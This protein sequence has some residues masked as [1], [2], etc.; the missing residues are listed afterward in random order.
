MTNEMTRNMVSTDKAITVTVKGNTKDN[1]DW[2]TYARVYAM[3]VFTEYLKNDLTTK[4]S[5]NWTVSINDN[6]NYV[7]TLTFDLI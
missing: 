6:N 2:Q 5:T 4:D 7:V 3:Q 1:K